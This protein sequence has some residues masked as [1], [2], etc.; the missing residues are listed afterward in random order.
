[1]FGDK[2]SKPKILYDSKKFSFIK[3]P[4]NASELTKNCITEKLL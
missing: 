4:N 2:K 3:G 1:M